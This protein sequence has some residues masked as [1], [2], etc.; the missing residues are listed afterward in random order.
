MITKNKTV[1]IVDDERLNINILVDLLESEFNLLVAKNGEQAL[2]RAF[3]SPTP[4]LILLD[5]MMPGMNGYEVL[6]RIR[7]E[8]STNEIPV[9]FVTALGESQ[10]E[11]R[12]FDLGAADYIHKPFNP[13]VVKAR[14]NTQLALR[15]AYKNLEE[16]NNQLIYERSVIEDITLRMRNESHNDIS[17][18]KTITTPVEKTAGDIILQ[19]KR[20]DG[21]LHLLVGDFTGHGLT[22]AVC[23]PMVDD[24]FQHMTNQGSQPEDII[25]AINQKLY[26]RLPINLFMAGVFIEWN[27]NERKLRL[28][29]CAMPE[30]FI[31]RD[32]AVLQEYTSKRT[33]LGIM[34]TMEIN[35]SHYEFQANP[36]DK[37]I[38]CSDGVV[39]TAN[40][41]QEMFG[42]KRLINEL[43]SHPISDLA[44][45]LQIFRD[46]AEQ[47]DD[48]TL[49]ELTC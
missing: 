37:V 45:T 25:Q 5:I 32:G 2:K 39:E 24:L 49:V 9:I 31:M 18:I 11:T 16:N 20:P 6:S 28:W 46:G 4:D 29:N 43:T 47:S 13:A 10:D 22:A 36:Y 15:Q 34:P 48:I 35:S 40:N 33:P 19:T 41:N 42:I 17:N 38:V 3:G 8:K 7:E 26:K 21:T 12:G 1:L 27:Q 44:N 14:V 30:I 23:A